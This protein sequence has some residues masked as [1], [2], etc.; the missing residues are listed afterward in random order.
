MLSPLH[1]IQKRGAVGEVDPGLKPTTTNWP[2]DRELDA[3]IRADLA[4]RQR[5]AESIIDHRCQSSARLRGVCLRV[6][7]QSVVKTDCRSHA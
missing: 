2:E 1:Q 7:E 4:A 5:L 6:A 3:G